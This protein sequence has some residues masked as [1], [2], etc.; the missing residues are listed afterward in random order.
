MAKYQIIRRRPNGIVG[1]SATDFNNQ[2]EVSA[3]QTMIRNGSTNFPIARITTRA[4]SRAKVASCGTENS[5]VTQMQHVR[6][7]ITGLAAGTLADRQ[8]LLKCLMRATFEAQRA[9][10]AGAIIGYS[11][12]ALDVDD[13]VSSLTLNLTGASGVTA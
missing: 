4:Q 5:C 6:I 10:K 12:D 3:S 7:E 2:V 1:G 8:E 13:T 11:P 9:L